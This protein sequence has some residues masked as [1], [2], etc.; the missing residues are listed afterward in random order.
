MSDAGAATFN[1]YVDLGTNNIYTGD[2]GKA[3][4]GS[5]E[6]LKIYH[7]GNN[8][9]ITEVG[10][11]NLDITSN[12]ANVSIMG[13]AGENSIIATG[14]GSVELYH[15]NTKKFETTSAGV[16]AQGRV[17]IQTPNDANTHLVQRMGS[18][19][20]TYGYA[21]FELVTPN[22]SATNLPRLDMQ[23]ANSN[24]LSLCRGGKVGIG[25]TAPQA[26]LSVVTGGNSGSGHSTG[27]QVRHNG[28]SGYKSGMTAGDTA[29][30]TYS[31]GFIGFIGGGHTGAGK[32]EI[33]FETRPGTTDAAC[34]ERL[35]ITDDG[36]GISSFTTRVWIRFDGNGTTIDDSHNVSSLGDW[37]TGDYGIYIQNG[38]GNT[39][40]NINCTTTN[41]KIASVQT[42]NTDTQGGR[43]DI[44]VQTH[45][46][47]HHDAQHVYA[48]AI[49]D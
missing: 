35:R 38:F 30:T 24:I 32:R 15:N 13:K 2:N 1:S 8:S 31:C 27:I 39:T 23:I 37:G 28:Y 3:V 19:S 26:E 22:S 14:D 7:D 44:E 4:F 17:E 5:N 42:S 16:T 29:A 43:F 45:S 9:Y 10:T 41:S 48:A 46:G 49:G 20:S 25:D 12:G 18:D 11:G 40:Y 33:I 47:S 36:R 34:T 6:D 21:D